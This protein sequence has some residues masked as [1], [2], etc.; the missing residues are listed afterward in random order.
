MN[1]KEQKVN[2]GNNQQEK[3]ITKELKISQNIFIYNETMIP[4][5]NISRVSVSDALRQPYQPYQFIMLFVGVCLLFTKSVW[6]VL[7]GLAIG[8]LAGWLLYKTYKENEDRGEYIVLSLNSGEKIFLHSTNHDFSIRI[9]DVIANCINSDS[10]REANVVNVVN[11]D[12]CSI[13]TC[14]MNEYKDNIFRG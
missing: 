6:G 4:L 7:I 1:T 2:I 10:R 14:N 9:M 3:I 13:E 11:M 5:Y 12:S 8:A